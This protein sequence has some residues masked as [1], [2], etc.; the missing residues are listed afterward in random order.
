MQLDSLKT[1]IGNADY[2]VDPDAVAEAIVRRVLA[3]RR[4]LHQ[5]V[6]AL[7]GPDSL[8]N[9]RAFETG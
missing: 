2:E 7:E 1:R 9:G 3:V 4:E 6:R 8:G 5:A